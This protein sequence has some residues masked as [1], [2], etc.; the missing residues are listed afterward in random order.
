M[1]AP[2]LC[3]IHAYLP[4]F[5]QIHRGHC[6]TTEALED[7]CD[8]TQFQ[9]HSLFSTK[10]NA[11][12]ILFYYDDVEV[13]NPLGSHTKKHKLGTILNFFLLLIEQQIILYYTYR[14]FLLSFG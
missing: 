7:Y 10:R 1:T 11:L 12:Q 13:C 14:Y 9:S 5:V 8:G 6:S 4:E 2:C 3:V